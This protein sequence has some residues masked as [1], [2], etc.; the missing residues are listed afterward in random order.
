MDNQVLSKI[1]HRIASERHRLGLTHGEL[2][3]ECGLTLKTISMLENGQREL[4]ADS[5]T[6]LCGCLHVSADYLLF[7][8]AIDSE[9]IYFKEKLSLL[10]PNVTQKFKELLEA[11]VKDHH[12]T[13]Y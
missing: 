9:A 4:K 7:G 11:L 6:R 10:E 3:I 12:G 2:A 13:I 8:I 5:L 1:G